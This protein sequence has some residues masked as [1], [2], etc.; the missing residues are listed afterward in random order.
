MPRQSQTKNTGSILQRVFYDLAHHGL[1]T[2][3]PMGYKVTK[4]NISDQ[5][6]RN[7]KYDNNYLFH[8]LNIP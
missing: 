1:V 7:L 8:N 4:Y 5:F 2:T 3:G 6:Q